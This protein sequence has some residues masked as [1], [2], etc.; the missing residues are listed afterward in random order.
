MNKHLAEISKCV[1]SGAIAVLVIDGAG[2][3]RAADLIVPDNIV[4]LRLPAY[5]P[6]LNPIENIWEYMRG[7]EFGHQ[8]CEPP[9]DFRRLQL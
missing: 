8:V 4:L 6:E 3:H 1:A 2:W 9:R 7:N 5:A